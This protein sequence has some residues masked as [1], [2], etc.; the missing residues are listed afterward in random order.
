MAGGPTAHQPQPLQIADDTVGSESMRHTH[1]CR[2][3]QRCA[4]VLYLSEKCCSELIE[5]CVGRFVLV[6]RPPFL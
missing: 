1:R 6:L 5:V 3:D 4:P 2:L